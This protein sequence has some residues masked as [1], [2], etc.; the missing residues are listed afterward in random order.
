[1]TAAAARENGLLSGPHRISHFGVRRVTALPRI[2]G[3]LIFAASPAPDNGHH[4]VVVRARAPR[5]YAVTPAAGSRRVIREGFRDGGVCS[6]ATTTVSPKTRSAD[7]ITPR[8]APPT[9]ADPYT[10]LAKSSR[11]YVHAT[12]HHLIPPPS[13]YRPPRPVPSSV[14]NCVP[15][16]H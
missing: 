4:L 7:Y 9:P 2:I 16:V 1:V 8:T 10:A 3:P 11:Y 6:R 5:D 15:A 14:R 13:R 12:R